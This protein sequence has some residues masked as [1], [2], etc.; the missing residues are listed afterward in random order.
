LSLPK[1]TL[2]EITEHC[3]GQECAYGYCDFFIKD[4]GCYFQRK[5]PWEWDDK[6]DVIR[7]IIDGKN[8]KG[9][10]E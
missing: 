4:N 6:L 7:D 9:K 8:Y 2:E 5:L 3:A 10:L 1:V